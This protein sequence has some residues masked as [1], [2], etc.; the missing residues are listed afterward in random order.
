MRLSTPDSAAYLEQVGPQHRKRL[1]QFFTPPAIADF[2]VEWALGSSSA[3]LYDPAFGLGALLQPPIGYE[4][5]EVAASEVDPA[6]LRFWTNATGR[7]ASFIANEDYLLS[8]G[9]QRENIVCNPPYMR[10]QNFRNR[11]AVLNAF[12]Q[13]LG[14]RLSGYTNTAS[15]FLIKSLSEIGNA[16]RLAYLMPLEFLNTGYGK[17]VKAKLIDGGH[18]AAI[19]S[20]D[21]ERDVFPD[22]IT[23][24]GIILYD[25]GACYAHGRFSFSCVD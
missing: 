6:I 12:S 24:V 19:I 14:L 22:V 2:M 5:V 11:D 13:N 8:W 17:L 15:A 23:S 25:A 10:F 3:S 4:G 1:G 7:D 18:L 21:R 20:L 9:R 16:G